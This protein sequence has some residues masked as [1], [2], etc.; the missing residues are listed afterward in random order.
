M[1]VLS[2]C[3]VCNSKRNNQFISCKDHFLTGESFNIIQCDE[4]GFRFT[5]PRPDENELGNYYQSTEYISH[6][7]TRKGVFNGIYQIVRKYTIA[8]KYR[9][10][11]Q[12]KDGN[13]ILDIGCATGEFLNYMKSKNWETLGIEPDVKAR[14]MARSRYGLKVFDEAYLDQVPDSSM[15]IITLWHVLEH[16]SDLSGRMKTL[17]RILKP[18]GF[19]VM[20]VPNSDSYDAGYYRDFWAG[21][22]VPRH[23][24]HF[25]PGS[26]KKLLTRNHFKL[27]ET[28]PMKF[29]A[30]YVSMLSEKYRQ[31]KLWWLSGIWKGFLSNWKARNTK[32]HSSLIFISAK[33]KVN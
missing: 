8:K 16:I 11:S 18:G 12:Y 28:K 27:I 10:I 15:D 1:T 30:Y 20:A 24:Y 21:Y 6:S 19:L 33:E 29:D 13:H 23:L 14:Q 22:D 4:C 7:N 2:S 32:N 3:P 5:N 31:R 9:M 25:S 26:M 17:E